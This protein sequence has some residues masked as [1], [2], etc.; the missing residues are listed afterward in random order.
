MRKYFKGINEKASDGWMLAFVAGCSNIDNEDWVV[1]TN[2]LHADQV[3]EYCNDAKLFAQLV[4]GLLNCYYN[5]INVVD[6]KE[7][8]ICKFGTVEKY[9]EIP[10]SKNTELPF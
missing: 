4:A 10:S 1:D 3:P 9:E 6:M 5:D 2:S 7:E 8:K